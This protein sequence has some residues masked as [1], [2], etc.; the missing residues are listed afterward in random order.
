MLQAISAEADSVGAAAVRIAAPKDL[1]PQTALECL[2]RVAAHHGVDLPAERLRHAYAVDG[3]PTSAE[4]L[5]RMA[6]EA[7]LRAQAVQLDW[8][9]LL[10]MG[11]AYPVLLRLSNGNW[12]VVLRAAEA[13]DGATAVVVFDPL[14]ERQDEP[15]IVVREAFCAQWRGDAILIK[16]ENLASDEQKAFGIRWF[17]PEL[18]R[19]WRLRSTFAWRPRHSAICSACR[20]PSSSTSRPAS[21]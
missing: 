3:K 2:A 5:L 4:L 9:A 20:S 13:S 16:R 10:Q 15:L 11:E 18:L 14:A 6:K 19:Q 1:C 7:G 21:W 8:D 17:V 12:V